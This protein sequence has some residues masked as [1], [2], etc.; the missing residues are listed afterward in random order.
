MSVR[1]MRHIGCANQQLSRHSEMHNPLDVPD[2]FSAGRE[3]IEDDMFAHAANP[4]DMASVKLLRH[5]CRRRLEGLRLGTQPHRLDSLTLNA[6]VYSV[7]NGFYFRKLGHDLPFS[8]KHPAKP[9]TISRSRPA[10]RIV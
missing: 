2:R 9:L 6:L 5:L 1:R 3:K 8:Q 7:G 4:L 10:K